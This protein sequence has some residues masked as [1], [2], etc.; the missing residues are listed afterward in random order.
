[1]VERE[2]PF[3]QYNVLI[4]ISNLPEVRSFRIVYQPTSRGS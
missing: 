2:E 1:M 3:I 4:I